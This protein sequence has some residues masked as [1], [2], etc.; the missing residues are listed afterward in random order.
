MSCGRLFQSVGPAAANARY[1]ELTQV[2]LKNLSLIWVK[3]TLNHWTP[4]ASWL[5]T[6]TNYQVLTDGRLWLE[7]SPLQNYFWSGLPATH[8]T[9]CCVC[10]A[11]AK[12]ALDRCTTICCTG[13]DNQ[14]IKMHHKLKLICVR[15]EHIPARGRFFA[16]VTL[17]LTS[18]TL[19]LEEGLNILTM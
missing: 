9:D 19:K 11:K 1:G 5:L 6:T 12:I 7:S 10:A 18:M 3:P 14:K 8:Y 15:R 4:I 16:I 13:A 2:I 17:I